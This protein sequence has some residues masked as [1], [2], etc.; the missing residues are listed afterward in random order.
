MLT[1]LGG[2]SQVGSDGRRR[3]TVNVAEK[4]LAWMRLRV[5]GTPG[6]GSMPYGS[7]NALVTAAEVVRR[8]AAARPGRT[9]A[10]FGR[11]VGS[12]DIPADGADAH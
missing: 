7:D 12:L 1:E 2:W 4:G 9:S 5:G 6:H 3:I 11:R 10:T 8:L